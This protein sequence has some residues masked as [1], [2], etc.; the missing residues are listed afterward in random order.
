MT[1]RRDAFTSKVTANSKVDMAA[2]FVPPFTSSDAFDTAMK[3]LAVMDHQ[4]KF[5]SYSFCLQCGVRRVGL[6]GTLEDWQLL[7]KY[8][9]GMRAFA[10]PEGT[11]DVYF[12]S[13]H[14]YSAWLDDL[15]DIADNLI[16]TYK[17]EPVVAW[18]NNM[19]TERRT[20]GSGASTYLKGWIIALVSANPIDQEME[21]SQIKG[22]R[23]SV[24]VKHDDNGNITKMRVLGGFTGTLYDAETD[25]WTPQ[26]SMAVLDDVPAE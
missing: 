9:S 13:K 20:Y 3:S 22:M 24:P 2:T 1:V 11:K 15:T 14:T 7:R 10:V 21:P 12:L 26:R 25:S 18:W 6:K 17:G 16:A 4:Q 23:F 5:F 19:I 8:I